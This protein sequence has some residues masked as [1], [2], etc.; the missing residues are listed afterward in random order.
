M[1]TSPSCTHSNSNPSIFSHS[2]EETQPHSIELET[3]NG[4]YHGFTWLLDM[5]NS[6]SGEINETHI[7][8]GKK[9]WIELTKLKYFS[10]TI[11]DYSNSSS[12]SSSN[13]SSSFSSSNGSEGT[14]TY[15]RSSSSHFG[16]QSHSL[17]HSN[18]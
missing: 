3:F 10:D 17:S 12:T 13:S 9:R 18:E 6:D 7:E 16:S 4:T 2:Y 5:L 1:C 8:N 14:K 11:Y 15:L